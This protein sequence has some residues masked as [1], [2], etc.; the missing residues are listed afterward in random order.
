MNTG[1]GRVSLMLLA[2]VGLLSVA[3]AGTAIA[4]PVP[5]ANG[6]VSA[7]YRVKGKAKGAMRVVSAGKKCK[8]G[9]RKLAWSVTGP[10][11]AQGATGA[12]GGQGAQGSPGSNGTNGA[13]G[14]PAT[15]VVALETKVA[16]LTLEVA[17]LE[18]ILDGVTNVGLTEA[19]KAVPQ[20]GALC[21]Q[22]TSLTSQSNLLG[23]A[24][25]GLSLSGVLG[26]LLNI[27]TLPAALPAFTC[28][29]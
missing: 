6:Q 7:C 29:S 1:L 3:L 25:G 8:K 2:L 12:Q 22:A 20:V 9:E 26:G 10:P 18:G 15:G 24:V 11:G 19:V 16:S 28:P 4:A 27:P 23:T 5:G 17:N 21:T 14:A 13:A